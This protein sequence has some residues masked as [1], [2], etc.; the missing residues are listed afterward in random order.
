VTKSNASL[1]ASVVWDQVVAEVAEDYADVKLDSLLADAAVA[2]LV[3]DPGAMMLDELQA[4][5]IA[6]TI[7]VAVCQVCASGCCTPDIGGS[8][9]SAEVAD[10]ILAA[11]AQ[12]LTA[13]T[14]ESP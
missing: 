1:H 11:A 3:L 8:A 14:E 9:T 12:Q 10:A 4:P 6:H 5:K 13:P 7:R 2:R